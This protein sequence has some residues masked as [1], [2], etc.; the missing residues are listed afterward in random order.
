LEAISLW[1][2]R[3]LCA[4]VCASDLELSS[5]LGLCDG[6]GFGAR[7]VHREGAALVVVRPGRGNGVEELLEFAAAATTTS[8]PAHPYFFRFFQRR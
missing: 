3:P 6:F 7:T 1:Y 8:L 4:V 5:A 2:Q